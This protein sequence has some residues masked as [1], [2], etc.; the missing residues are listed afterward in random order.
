M[1]IWVIQIY[2]KNKLDKLKKK[3][4]VVYRKNS[5]RI[6]I[7][8]VNIPTV[9]SK[10]PAPKF[11]NGE[12]FVELCKNKNSLSR[13]RKRP[14]NAACCQRGVGR[15]KQ[16]AEKIYYHLQHLSMDNHCRVEELVAVLPSLKVEEYWGGYQVPSTEI[17]GDE[18]YSEN[19]SFSGSKHVI[20]AC[21]ISSMWATGNRN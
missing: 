17:T 11:T 1:D 12:H 8:P 3:V 21:R 2:R 10:L 20:L 13:N 4:I 7:V 15:N 16:V 18:I 6:K 9:H 5:K 19:C 14:F